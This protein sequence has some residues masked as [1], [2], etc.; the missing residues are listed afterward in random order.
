MF[1]SSFSDTLTNLTVHPTVSLAE[2]T[3][4]G[5]ENIKREYERVS[6]KKEEL[7]VTIREMEDAQGR[8]FQPK[9]SMERRRNLPLGSEGAKAKV[10]RS[11]QRP[12]PY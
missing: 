4:E 8:S 6:K 1:S 5:Y 9:M 3:E 2:E 10:G 7:E 12:S 11:N